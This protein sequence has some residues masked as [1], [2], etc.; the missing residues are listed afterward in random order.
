MKIAW[1]LFSI[2]LSAFSFHLNAQNTFKAI[3]KDDATEEPIIGAAATIDSLKI[4]AVTDTT[5]LVVLTHIP[6][7][8]FQL[9]FKSMGYSTTS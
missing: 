1:I 3:L 2:V 4:G 9:K 6:N 8:N 5:G 7:G